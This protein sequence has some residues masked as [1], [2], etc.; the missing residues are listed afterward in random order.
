MKKVKS[1]WLG[2]KFCYNPGTQG[3]DDQDD[4]T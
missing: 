1:S 2:E 4:K 3:S